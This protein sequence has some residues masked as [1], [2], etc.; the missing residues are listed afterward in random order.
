[1]LNAF[2]GIGR[3]G[4]GA[5]AFGLALALT[6]V[7]IA[8][9]AEAPTPEGSVNM[10]KALEPGPLPELA[11]GDA[12][13]IPLIE[14]GSVTCSH[15]A[16]F[17]HDIWPDFKKAYVDTGKVRYI[18]R[19]Y[20]RNPLDVAAFMLARCEGDD[21]TYATIELLFATQDKWAFVDRP[22]EGL[23]DVMRTA[24]MNRDQVMACLKDQSK[25][26]A[27]TQIAKT[28]DQKIAVKGTPTFV[29]D[30]KV[31]GGALELGE[32]DAILKPLIK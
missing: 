4:F 12:A 17:A 7:A 26:D 16:H 27:F 30:G 19:E 32:L 23:V 14:Y 15:C 5:L 20:S 28:A 8:G 21:K 29:I 24:G 18:F 1:M 2:D 22:L 13:G 31:Y 6:R 3:R 11:I 9:A 10:A 25:A